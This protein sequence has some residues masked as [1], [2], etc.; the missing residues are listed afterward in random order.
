MAENFEMVAKTFQGLEGVLAQ[1]LIN[2][3]AKD[4]TEGRRMVSF[5]GDKE[6]MYRANFCLRT[7]VRIL[8]PFASFRST[9]ADEL[10]EQVSRIHWEDILTPDSTF[11]IDATIFSEIFRHSQFATYRVK[12]AIADYFMSKYN[13]RPSIR[14]KNPDIL[15]NVH[16]A[17]DQVT[18][19]LDSS[20]EPLFKRGWRAAQTD[21]PINEVLAA[22]ILLLAGYDGS[23]PLVDPMCGSGTF[24][25]EAALIATGTPP[26]VYRRNFGF[27]N[28]R[29]YDEELFSE[30]YNDD[31]MEREFNGKIY[32][33]DILGKAIAISREN[34]KSAG[35]EKHIELLRQDIAD[36]VQAP[37]PNGLLVTNPPYGHRLKM[38]DINM[39]YDTL[40]G[41]LK[42]V[43]QG[44]DAWI[45]G[46]DHETMS[47]I[48]LH[49][50]ERI[51]L[52]NGALECEL[53][54]YE[55]YSGSYVDHRASRPREEKPRFTEERK[56][57]PKTDTKPPFKKWVK[58]DDGF[59]RKSRFE[60]RFEP[61]RDSRDSI[62]E[63]GRVHGDAINKRI[64]RFRK[65][66]LGEDKERTIIHGRR[67]SWKRRDLPED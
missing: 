36:F 34:I 45:I 21:A 7:A 10:Y 22:G 57:R 46:F 26:G 52:H 2:L 44:Y 61:R 38:D 17:E 60:P 25:I 63:N 66:Q 1:E 5:T 27:Q 13:K 50:D 55:I 62:D 19:S 59:E 15:I 41:R 58:K 24:L 12:D 42:H 6:M 54:H 14:I 29:D 8:K 28:W 40:G 67:K 9:S 56:N 31:S 53:R 39:L 32:G 51:P 30:I 4:V 20:G 64:V 33:Y 48:G 18:L 37:E 23:R 35:M 11:A 3:G 16:I 65:P 47:N 49:A 43:F